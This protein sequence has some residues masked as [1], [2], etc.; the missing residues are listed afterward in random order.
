[1]IGLSSYSYEAR[2]ARSV[3]IESLEGRRVKS[4][5]VYVYKIVFNLV[6]T[7]SNNFF[8]VIGNNCVTRGR[9]FK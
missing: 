7:D 6:D 5:L 3:R 9:D 4:D 8:S 1:M 2:L